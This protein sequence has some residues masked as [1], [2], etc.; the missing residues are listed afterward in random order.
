LS[1]CTG[2]VTGVTVIGVDGIGG[3][4]IAQTRS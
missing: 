3:T 1:S 4:G 2:T